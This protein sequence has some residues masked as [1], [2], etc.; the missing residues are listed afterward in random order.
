MRAGRGRGYNAPIFISITSE[1]DWATGKTHPLGNCMAGMSPTLW[2]DYRADDFILNVAKGTVEPLI[3][4]AYYYK[5]TPGHNPL[6]VN[7]FIEPYTIEGT[8]PPANTFPTVSTD[9]SGIQKWWSVNMP[10]KLEANRK[11]SRY[12]AYR[13]VAWAE[14]GRETAYWI[15]RC[16]EEIISGHNDIWN[17]AALDMYEGF[18]LIAERLQDEEGQGSAA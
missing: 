18:H 1:A 12:E 11:W 13:P 3:P 2:R 6:L 7:R 10:P 8:S 9:K 15:V 16:P 4:Q 5:H 14:A 17:P